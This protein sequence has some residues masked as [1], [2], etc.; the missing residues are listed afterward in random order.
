MGGGRIVKEELQP[1]YDRIAYLEHSRK[2]WQRK[3]R[4]LT[5]E[6]IKLKAE[7][8]DLNYEILAIGEQDNE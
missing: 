3:A 8:E 5:D 2:D 1:L 4:E 7:I 6:V